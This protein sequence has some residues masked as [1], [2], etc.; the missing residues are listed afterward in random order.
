VQ[1]LHADGKTWREAIRGLKRQLANVIY[2]ELLDETV[3][4]LIVNRGPKG[5][6]CG[7]AAN[8]VLTFANRT[9]W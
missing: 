3:T 4:Q 7:K 9:N 1:R 2:C 6:K 5:T 8:Q